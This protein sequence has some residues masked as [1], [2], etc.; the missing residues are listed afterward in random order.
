MV[1]QSYRKLQIRYNFRG[2]R[3]RLGG[4]TLEGAGGLNIFLMLVWRNRSAQ[5]SYT[6]EVGGSSPSASTPVGVTH[7]L[8]SGTIRREVEWYSTCVNKG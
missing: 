7:R 4:H 6:H 2:R 1:V 8:V 3:M 5:M